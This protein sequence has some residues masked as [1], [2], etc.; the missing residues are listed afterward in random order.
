MPLLPIR[1]KAELVSFLPW[2]IVR[3]L[4]GS[5]VSL[6]FSLEETLLTARFI[7]Q[8][9]TYPSS[10]LLPEE[11]L[12]VEVFQGTSP[13]FSGLSNTSTWSHST[14]S[15]VILLISVGPTPP[16]LS[17]LLCVIRISPWLVWLEVYQFYWSPPRA[18]LRLYC[19]SMIFLCFCTI[20]FHSDLYYFL[21]PCILSFIYFSH[22][23]FTRLNVRPLIWDLSPFLLYVISAAAK[24]TGAGVVCSSNFWYIL[25]NFD[26]MLHNSPFDF[27]CGLWVIEKY[28]ILL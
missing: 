21:P 23:G 15:L 24:G 11:A 13:F 14:H 16:P 10:T 8:I 7:R 18:S 5:H 9:H 27:P 17:F 2:L 6:A 22:S 1:G 26:P 19:F 12:G 20:D 3:T 4:Q 28:A 25:F